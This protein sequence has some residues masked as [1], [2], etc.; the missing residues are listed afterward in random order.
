V[1]DFVSVSQFR[2]EMKRKQD[3]SPIRALDGK[4][5]RHS[6]KPEKMV[7]STQ[8]QQRLSSLF[9]SSSSFQI[10]FDN[11]HENLQTESM[12]EP[13]QDLKIKITALPCFKRSLQSR[14]AICKSDIEL[15]N[16]KALDVVYV[17]WEK[18]THFS[19]NVFK[20]CSAENLSEELLTVNLK[21]AG[22]NVWSQELELVSSCPQDRELDNF[23]ELSLQGYKEAPLYIESGLASFVHPYSI[24]E[25]LDGFVE[26]K[27]CLSIHGTGERLAILRKDFGDFDLKTLL[28]SASKIIVWMKDLVNEKMQY[29]EVGDPAIAESCYKAGHSLYFN[30]DIELQR[31]YLEQFAEDLGLIATG[32][33]GSAADLSRIG[34]IEMF[35]VQGR[36]KTPW[37]Y[38]AQENFT[39]QLSGT[40]VW[41]LYKGDNDPISNLHLSSSNRASVRADKLVHHSYRSCSVISP[42]DFE[43]GQIIKV[44]MHPGS[45]LYFPGGTWHSVEAIEDSG[46]LSMNFSIDSARW[47]DVFISQIMPLLWQ[48]ER[49]RKRVTKFD[50]ASGRKLMQAM[51]DLFREKLDKLESRHIIPNSLSSFVSSSENDSS[52]SSIVRIL[53]GEFPEYDEVLDLAGECSQLDA[54]SKLQRNPLVSFIQCTEE[55]HTS[56]HHGQALHKFEVYSGYA[57]S[58]NSGESMLPEHTQEIWITETLLEKAQSLTKLAPFEHMVAESTELTSKLLKWLMHLGYLVPLQNIS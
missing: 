12:V 57:H 53:D 9:S 33:E 21:S 43:E 14:I 54:N 17:N 46:S 19:W 41:H 32:S 15:A 6:L 7:T 22:A 42:D 44:V 49:W 20:L 52:E 28:A 37:H 3:E 29:I 48:D 38:D 4:R 47:C 23:V 24:P 1:I 8:Q 31:K 40:K 39:I 2:G 35:A 16:L 55:P 10:S 45:V 30:P 58:S 13:L 11:Q 5:A 26:N 18:S 56:K 51:L 50:P 25:F 34:D 27:K 36:H